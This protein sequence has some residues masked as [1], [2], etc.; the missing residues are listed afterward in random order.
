MAD[1][2]IQLLPHIL[3]A[4]IYGALG[5]HFWNTRWRETEN[6][7]IACP[8]QTWERGAIAA[9]LSIHAWGLHDALFAEAGMRFSFSFA[10]SLMMWLA[11]L[12]YWLESFMARM[13]GMQPMVLPLAAAC[14]VLPVIFPERASGCPCPGHGFQAALPGSHARL[15][16]AYPVGPARHI[17][18]LHRTGSAQSLAETQPGQPATTADHGIAAV[19]DV[20]DRLCCCSRWLSAAAC[21]SPR[22]CLASHCPLT[23]RPCLP[24][25][26]GASSPPC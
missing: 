12:I 8:M 21:S 24:S 20:A 23:T 19:Q 4:L 26:P 18:G 22:N 1:I 10:L 11:A 5:F 16:P 3:A 9:A 7:C 6:Q 2:V 14:T 25:P 15:Q 13:E 17:H